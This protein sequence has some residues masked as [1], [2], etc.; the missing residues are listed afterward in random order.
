MTETV[1]NVELTAAGTSA[2]KND[3]RSPLFA[4]WP[5]YPVIPILFVAVAVGAYP[6]TLYNSRRQE[7]VTV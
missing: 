3:C 7:T 5:R 2:L 6:L 1:W 4:N